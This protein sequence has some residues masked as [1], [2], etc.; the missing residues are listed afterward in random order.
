MSGSATNRQPNT[1]WAKGKAGRLPQFIFA[2]GIVSVFRGLA[3]IASSTENLYWPVAVAI[4]LLFPVGCGLV[5]CWAAPRVARGSRADLTVIVVA[6][7][8]L[9]V[10]F[11]LLGML[12][13]ERTVAYD[14]AKGQIP[15]GH[16]LDQLLWGAQMTA[17]IVHII[18][19]LWIIVAGIRV[20]R[21]MADD[22]GT[23]SPVSNR[24]SLWANLL[25]AL[26]GILGGYGWALVAFFIGDWLGLRGQLHRTEFGSAWGEKDA[27]LAG[28]V[29]LLSAG[30]LI[31]AN[32]LFRWRWWGP[33]AGVLL[34]LALSF[35]ALTH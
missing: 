10:P 8:I 32:V 23:G 30:A 21:G 15:S 24:P 14:N 35:A 29:A 1:S 3:L 25:L 34:G 27:Q 2:A 17:V 20:R 6:S 26:V 4:A 12:E 33:T 31:I 19:L 11:L 16:L 5:Y 9:L 28:L 7:A 22:T 13:S 18:L